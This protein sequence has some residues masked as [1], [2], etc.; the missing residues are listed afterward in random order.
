VAELIAIGH[1]DTTTAVR[2]MY[3]VGRSA[4]ALVNQRDAVAAVAHDGGVDIR[5]IT[6]R[7]HWQLD[8]AT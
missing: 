7:F 2:P 4:K 1:A 6:N 3:D 5:T 8:G